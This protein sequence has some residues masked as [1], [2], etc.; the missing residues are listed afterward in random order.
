MNADTGATPA[1]PATIVHD[2]APL[3]VGAGLACAAAVWLVAPSVAW[4]DSG[5]LGAAAV[6]LGVPHPTG[7]PGFCLAGHTARQVPVGSAGMR[8]HLA[9]AACA[10]LAVAVWLRAGLDAAWSRG[11]RAAVLAAAATLPL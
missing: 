1:A 5:E 7:F 11:G 2:D 9:G 10:A 6:Q 3:Y 8:I 4:F